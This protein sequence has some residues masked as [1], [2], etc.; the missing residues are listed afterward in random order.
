MSKFSMKAPKGTGSGEGSNVDWDGLRTHTLSKVGKRQSR[1]ARLAGVIDL[2]MQKRED[3]SEPYLETN[4]DHENAI[5]NKNAQ[6]RS[7]KDNKTGKICDMI[8]IPMK[9]SS[10]VAFVVDFPE[11]MIDTGKFFNKDATSALTPFRYVLGGD[12]F[13]K[14]LGFGDDSKGMI[15]SS[16]SSLSMTKNDKIEGSWGYS[17]N[18]MVSKLALAIGLFEEALIPQDFD[19]GEMIGGEFA[20]T[21]GQVENGK[22]V[23]T[24]C[25]D[26]AMKHEA[27]PSPAYDEDAMC[28]GISF[29]GGNEEDDLKNN[30]IMS[31]TVMNTIRRS[32]TYATSGLKIQMDKIYA[33][34]PKGDTSAEAQAA[35]QSNSTGNAAPAKD[36]LVSNDNLSDDDAANVFA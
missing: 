14:D 1:I 25:K 35:N 5:K 13:V 36:D 17:P 2:G 34:R 30:S 32:S 19:L 23:N 12:F 28:F 20:M 8:Y 16:P 15:L 31:R 9:D 3:F 18:N 7:G 21:L 24:V 27:I 33:E 11:I 26:P 6:V 29:A 10:Q 22:Y 4:P